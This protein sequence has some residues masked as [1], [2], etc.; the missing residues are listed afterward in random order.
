M[1]L[2]ELIGLAEMV[3]VAKLNE[4]EA[5][6]RLIDAQ[7]A[8]ESVKAAS[9]A[10]AYENGVIDGKNADIRKQ[11]EVAFLTTNVDHNDALYEA[12]QLQREADAAVAE[13]AGIETRAGLVKA[14]LYSQARI[15]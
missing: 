10:Y 1:E 4:F 6:R 2:K 5:R 9:L 3:R 11:Q 13:L 14:W 12:D 15:G 8:V 7:C